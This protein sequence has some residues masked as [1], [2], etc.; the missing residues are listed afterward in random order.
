MSPNT[1]NFILLLLAALAL[2]ATAFPIGSFMTDL[3]IRT[4]SACAIGHGCPW[5]RSE[6]KVARAEFTCSNGGCPWARSEDKVA[7]A[8]TVCSAVHGCPWARSED[9]VAHGDV[10]Q[11]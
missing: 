1:C 11:A 10:L 6:D 9:K 3:A 2:T 8:E 7:R 4:E 5:A